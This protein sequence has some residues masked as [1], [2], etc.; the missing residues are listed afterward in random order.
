M[1]TVEICPWCF[2]FPT[3]ISGQSTRTSGR[4]LG[5]AHR[6]SETRTCCL[7]DCGELQGNLTALLEAQVKFAV[8]LPEP[9]SCLR[10]CPPARGSG[11]VHDP[12]LRHSR[13]GVRWV[14]YSGAVDLSQFRAQCSYTSCFR[15]RCLC[16]LTAYPRVI[17]QSG[18]N[19][20]Q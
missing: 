14:R 1:C 2:S 19:C 3:R 16:H 8:M 13:G 9:H 17:Q 4:D 5:N 6:H 15:P 11:V 20:S 7:G 12:E 18:S 10:A